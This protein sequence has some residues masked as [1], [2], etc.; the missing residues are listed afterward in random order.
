MLSPLN[1][2]WPESKN[3]EIINL[4]KPTMVLV[5]DDNPLDIEFDLIKKVRPFLTE[6]QNL[7]RLVRYLLLIPFFLPMLRMLFYASG[8]TGEPKKASL[9]Q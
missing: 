3:L 1:T 5:D 2:S 4:I 8:S 6:N 7:K 9:Y